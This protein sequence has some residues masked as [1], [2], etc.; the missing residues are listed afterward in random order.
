M[1][2]KPAPKKASAKTGPWRAAYWATSTFEFTPAQSLAILTAIPHK[3]LRRPS[4]IAEIT[5]LVRDALDYIDLIETKPP[6]KTVRQQLTLL[7]NQAN[8]LLSTLDSLSSPTTQFLDRFAYNRHIF[9]A[10]FRTQTSGFLSSVREAKAQRLW[11]K[12]AQGG[13]PRNKRLRHI[14]AM[15]V[16]WWHT[17][18]GELPDSYHHGSSDARDDYS[19]HFHAFAALI[20]SPLFGDRGL[21][22]VIERSVAEYRHLMEQGGKE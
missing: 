18:L 3:Q 2:P 11:H 8:K 6:D 13:R 21:D 20:I 22:A 19:G 16:H 17:H 10:D 4:T 15:L 14:T 9:I 1:K 7:E 12:S 5:A